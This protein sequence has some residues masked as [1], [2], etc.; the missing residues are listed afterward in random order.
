MRACKIDTLMKNNIIAI[1]FPADPAIP[2]HPF[3][4]FDNGKKQL[5]Q[6]R[7]LLI[8]RR[9]LNP[10]LAGRFPSPRTYVATRPVVRAYRLLPMN[11]QQHKPFVMP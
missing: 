3:D 6:Y 1:F 7:G 5:I 4:R 2:V 8:P 11:N 10:G 9:R